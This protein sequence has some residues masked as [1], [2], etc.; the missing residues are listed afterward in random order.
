[1]IDEEPE[2]EEEAVQKVKSKAPRKAT[3]KRS[4]APKRTFKEVEEPSRPLSPSSD[5]VI[6]LSL[7][8]EDSP[9]LH[10]LRRTIPSPAKTASSGGAV[11]KGGKKRSIS[12]EDDDEEERGD[13]TPVM[14]RSKKTRPSPSP[15][16]S[17]LL[18]QTRGSDEEEEWIEDRSITAA[19]ASEE[20]SPSW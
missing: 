9:P 18:P 12:S 3:P 7:L 17:R 20:A 1:V 13:D 5:D 6:K 2:E 15:L 16:T 11:R 10:Q 14:Q 4:A 19:A 8:V